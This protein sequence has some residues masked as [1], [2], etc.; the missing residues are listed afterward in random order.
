MKHQTPTE[1]AL[2]MMQY[3]GPP[4]NRAIKLFRKTDFSIQAVKSGERPKSLPYSVCL[5]TT[6]QLFSP[7]SPNA[8]LSPLTLNP[9]CKTR[10]LPAKLGP[11]IKITTIPKSY[12]ACHVPLQKKRLA[13][14]L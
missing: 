9:P 10:Y 3:P 14:K 8:P 5:Y 2:I 12:V 11:Y 4:T 13:N 1:H 7:V 6:I